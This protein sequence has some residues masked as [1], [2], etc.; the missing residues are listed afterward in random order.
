MQHP[1]T[2]LPTKS[3]CSL[4]SLHQ[5]STWRKS[6]RQ[7]QISIDK[8]IRVSV[9]R[10]LKKRGIYSDVFTRYFP[11]A[12]LNWMKRDSRTGRT[13]KS[14]PG[15]SGI[16]VSLRAAQRNMECSTFSQ[17]S[18]GKPIHDRQDFW[19]FRPRFFVFNSSLFD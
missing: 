17:R 5:F 3:R 15:K 2:K 10:W 1:D 4:N 13:L 7:I 18:W 19:L 6:V 8:K 16:S 9:H 11:F 14:L 12:R